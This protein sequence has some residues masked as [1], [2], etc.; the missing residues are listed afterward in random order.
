MTRVTLTEKPGI[1]TS[2]AIT[3]HACRNERE[4]AQVIVRGTAAQLSKLIYQFEPLLSP[5]GSSL[6]APAVCQ[7]FDVRISH[8]SPD[9][10]LPAGWY[11]DA[12]VPMAGEESPSLASFRGETGDVNLRLWID[13]HVPASQAPGKYSGKMLL[14]DS[15]NGEL[16]GS[17]RI[18]VHVRPET[19]P[20]KPTLKSYLGLEEHRIA[21]I[22]GLDRNKNGVALA[23]VMDDYYQLL[24]DSR[25]QPGLLFASSPPIGNDGELLWTLPASDT[26][27]APAAI[28]GKYLRPGGGMNCLHL[29]MWRDYPFADPLGDDRQKAVDYLAELASLT[30]RTSA[31]A[32]LFFSVGRLDEPDTAQAYQNIRDWAS[33]VQDAAKTAGTPIKFFVTEQPQPQQA[34]WGSLAGS[35]DIWAPQ[36][37]WA[38]EDLESKTGKS[39]IAGRIK[40]GDEVWCYPALAQFRDQWKKEKGKTDMARGSYPP[41]WLTDFPA[42]NYRILP[43]ICAAHGLTGIHYWNVFEWKDGADPWSDAGIFTI[44]DET[45]NGDGLLIYPPAPAR[46]V[47]RKKAAAMQPCA[48]IRLKWI[49]D[50]MEDYEHL[51]LLKGNNPAAAAGILAGIARGFGDWE[52]SV[53]KIEATRISISK[54]LMDNPTINLHPP[55]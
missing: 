46:L 22:H 37:M 14:R 25:L 26:L 41:V 55:P 12:L 13:C 1:E 4:S 30:R 5:H 53:A 47:G 15:E 11:P 17:A 23:Q 2:D 33:L 40:A 20:D 10:P 36:V 6:P 51:Q 44:G 49:R 35:V 24:I 43:W 29:P 48:S 19:L 3:I 18:T 54:A 39:I 31:D 50:G 7:E 16:L 32:S 8:S 21:R 38:W 27:P 42:V 28:V 52:T 9:A 45:F 34:D